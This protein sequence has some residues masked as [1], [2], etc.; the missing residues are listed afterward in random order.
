MT[1][2]LL[3]QILE[4]EA[5]PLRGQL[6]AVAAVLTAALGPPGRELPPD[7]AAR[8]LAEQ[9]TSTAQVCRPKQADRAS[10]SAHEAFPDEAL[11]EAECLCDCAPSVQTQLQKLQLAHR[12]WWHMS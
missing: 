3:T 1:Y 7:A 12:Y 8:V 6:A 4:A 2:I 9:A 11:S 5:T 10:V